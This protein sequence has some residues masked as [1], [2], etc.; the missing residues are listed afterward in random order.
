MVKTALDE[1]E[2]IFE[3]ISRLRKVLESGNWSEV[4]FELSHQIKV[5]PNSG[6][7]II[8]GSKGAAAAMR[9]VRRA[10]KRVGFENRVS[11]EK[12]REIFSQH[13]YERYVV[14]P[15]ELNQKEAE[16][17]IGAIGR[18]VKSSIKSFAFIF[19]AFVVANKD[20][21]QLDLGPVRIRSHKTTSRRLLEIIKLG[22]SSLTKGDE[23][24]RLHRTDMASAARHYRYFGWSFEVQVIAV[25]AKKAQEVASHTTQRALD[26]FAFLLGFEVASQ[27]SFGEVGR[28]DKRYFRLSLHENEHPT[29]IWG[30][31]WLHFGRSL[32]DNWVEWFT[33]DPY[34][35]AVQLLSKVIA[36]DAN[37]DLSRP[38][39]F[40]IS[41]AISIFCTASRNDILG[42]RIVNLVVAMEWV[43]N[44]NERGPGVQETFSTRVAA[45]CTFYEGGDFNVYKSQADEVYHV[46]S[47]LVHGR[48]SRFD[49]SLESQL[50][51]AIKLAESSIFGFLLAVGNHGLD[52]DACSDRELKSKF[53]SLV[54]STSE[55]TP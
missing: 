27:T 43:T 12:G 7:Q 22:N 39:C 35:S 51:E 6:R 46:R 28:I 33:S 26:A 53:D 16:R 40:R 13:F 42:D 9:I 30:N 17:L 52:L 36:A 50:G 18:S 41:E 8:I 1:L 5:P 55:T 2:F 45:L 44:T 25:D 15:R 47:A 19:P 24:S 21:F 38:L 10:A 32:A 54:V 31:S 29:T 14:H 23:M 49:Q 37:P 34:P 48:L 3:E 4:G 20:P 11:N